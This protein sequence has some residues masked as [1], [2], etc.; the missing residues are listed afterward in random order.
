MTRGSEVPTA[1]GRQREHYNKIGRD[2]DE[3]Y[4]DEWS[5]RYR[6]EFINSHLTFGLELKGKKVL[7]A[8]CGS[9]LTTPHLLALGAEVVGLDISDQA[10]SR[11]S[12]RWP[13]CEGVAGSILEAPWADSTFDACVIMGGLHHLHPHVNEALLEIHRVVKPGGYLCFAEPLKGA[14]PDLARRLWY[15]IDPLFERNEESI[16]P[17]QLAYFFRE[18]FETLRSWTGGNIAYLLVFNSMVLR[19]PHALKAL[20]S[21]PLFAVERLLN[22]TLPASM[23]CYCVVQ[24]RKMS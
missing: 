4:G 14:L 16:D 5:A 9:G 2:Y 20:L 24:W 11:F 10:I 6:D 7:E 13:N 15:R 1:E 8:M 17:Q 3:H 19:I 22:S 23:K 12:E 21:R 18:H